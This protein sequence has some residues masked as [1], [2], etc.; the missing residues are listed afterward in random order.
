MVGRERKDVSQDGS[1]FTDAKKKCYIEEGCRRQLCSLANKN[2]GTHTHMDYLSTHNLT[3]ALTY[4]ETYFLLCC[5]INLW[6]LL[7]GT[8]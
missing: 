2:T 1:I 4:F 8:A 6:D 3:F 5:L 7:H